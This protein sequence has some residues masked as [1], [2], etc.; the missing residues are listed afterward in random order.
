MEHAKYT[1][2]SKIGGIIYTIN[3][4]FRDTKA[5]IMGDSASG[6]S[7]VYQLIDAEQNEENLEAVC[8]NYKSISKLKKDMESGH[9]NYKGKL[10]VFDNAEILFNRVPSVV[11]EINLN[12]DN[13]YLIFARNAPGLDTSPNIVGSLKFENNT[14]SI[15][16]THSE[17]MWS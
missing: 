8:Y 7:L 12:I 4:I 6:K 3:L 9:L 13:N 2:N 5:I 11:E 14:Y 1:F 16:Y 10:V 15:Q 17:G